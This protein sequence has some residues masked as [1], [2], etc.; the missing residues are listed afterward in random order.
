M[1]KKLTLEIFEAVLA[2][3]VS[4]TE[5]SAHVIFQFRIMSIFRPLLP[6]RVFL[7]GI[8]PPKMSYN[9]LQKFRSYTGSVR[10]QHSAPWSITPCF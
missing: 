8:I 10:S 3:A 7:D 4:T 6:S 2:T 5:D 9:P 1:S